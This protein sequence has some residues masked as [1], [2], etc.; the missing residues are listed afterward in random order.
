[1][2]P[3]PDDMFDDLAGN[4]DHMY[5]FIALN[6]LKF[7]MLIRDNFQSFELGRSLARIFSETPSPDEPDAKARARA[8]VRDAIDREATRLQAILKART[9]EVTH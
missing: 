2:T 5:T 4:H 3:T 7:T 1:M 8:I 6:L 9:P